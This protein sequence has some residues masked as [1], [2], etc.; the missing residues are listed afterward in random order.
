M[1]GSGPTNIIVQLF[2]CWLNFNQDYGI[3][4]LNEF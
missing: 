1:R 4:L 2:Y 3:D